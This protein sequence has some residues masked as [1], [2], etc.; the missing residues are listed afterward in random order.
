MR[1]DEPGRLGFFE[2]ILRDFPD[3]LLVMGGDNGPAVTPR[4]STIPTV[5]FRTEGLGDPDAVVDLWQLEPDGTLEFLE[6]GL[7]F[8]DL[9][10]PTARNQEVVFA[11]TPALEAGLQ[12]LSELRVV[13]GVLLG[14]S[15][16]AV[17]GPI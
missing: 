6:G 16:Q 12:P 14:E 4:I 8:D 5:G 2:M 9:G 13:G 1:V 15:Q 11:L 3:G 10:H 7:G 17:D